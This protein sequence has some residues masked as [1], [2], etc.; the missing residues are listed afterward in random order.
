M[1][2]ANAFMPSIQAQPTQ[3]S[4]AEFLLAEMRHRM[5]NNLQAI[6]SLLRITKS[7]TTSPEARQALSEIEL[8]VGAING[9]DGQLLPLGTAHPVA[10]GSHL[11]R[12]AANLKDAF[13]DGANC[14]F[15]LNLENLDVDA[16]A[17]RALGLIFNEAVTNSFK[18]SGTG[19][20]EIEIS[21]RRDGDGAIMTVADNGLGFD[22]SAQ[23]H[24]GGTLLIYRMAQRIPATLSCRSG[25]DGTHYSLSF[26]CLAKKHFVSELSAEGR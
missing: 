15:N 16:A 1:T 5:K 14:R 25:P 3:D 24:R 10:L 20:I 4:D 12:L 11:R 13:G 18:H 8:H 22:V 23:V 7:R 26:P 17:A 2:P 19:F 9:V 6:Q 21:L